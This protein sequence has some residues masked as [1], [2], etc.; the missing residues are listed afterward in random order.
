MK[1]LV[2]AAEASAD[3]YAAE[4]VERL[5]ER[6]PDADFFG[7][8]GPRMRAAGVRPVVRT[9]SLSVVGVFE[10]LIHAPRI[11]RLLFLLARTAKRERP[12]FAVV[13]DA[14][15][16]H[17]DLCRF[18][19]RAGVPIFYY[20]A[21]Q[22]WAW[23]KGR[24]RV[25]RR[26]VSHL[27]CIFPFEEKFFLDHDVAT[28]YV[29]HPLSRTTKTTM[30]RRE[31]LEGLG[32]RGDRPVVAVAPGSRRAEA[33]RHLP[34]LLDAIKRVGAVLPIDAV[35]AASHTTGRAFFAER[36]G[37]SPVH[38]VEDDLHNAIGHADLALVASGTAAVE[39]A[40]LGT[41]MVVFY[42]V[43]G[44]TWLLGKMLADVPFYSMVNLL[45]GR[46]IVPELIQGDC[47]AEKL[48][49][50][51]RR[52]LENDQERQQMCRELSVI[53]EVLGGGQP[54]A[55]RAVEVICNKL[56][57]TRDRNEQSVTV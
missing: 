7:C 5:R 1:I 9:E 25:I 8:A 39:T 57:L 32:I 28:T 21:P 40:L 42:R 38:I 49:G 33:E 48:A 31:F 14:P 12:D 6:F 37:D 55:E 54:A 20:V 45:A 34:Y 17:L 19:K 27:L 13:T 10:V 53:A 43:T 41:P 26:L 2:S 56:S 47:T 4:L 30:P 52:L 35:L 50:E 23:R 18:L 51:A 29:G 15:G 46:R 24:I 3:R 44:A 22:V 16:F 11:Y 36:I